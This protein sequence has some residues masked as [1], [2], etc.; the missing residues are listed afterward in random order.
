MTAAT[1]TPPVVDED[2][3]A[4]PDWVIVAR[5]MWGEPPLCE[6]T[7]SE[8]RAAVWLLADQG[9]RQ[10]EVI[11]HTRLPKRAVESVYDLRKLA[12]EPDRKRGPHGGRRPQDVR[13]LAPTQELR[14]IL[15]GVRGPV[16]IDEALLV[17][18]MVAGRRR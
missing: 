11:R 18:R 12:Q 17:Q 1:L 13:E 14:D 2:R 4:R 10:S 7:R 9:Y 3:E 6:P 15:H 16:R 5:I 8:I